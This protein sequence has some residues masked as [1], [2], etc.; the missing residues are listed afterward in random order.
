MPC[1]NCSNRLARPMVRPHANDRRYGLGLVIC[2]ELKRADGR[3][4]RVESKPEKSTVFTVQLPCKK[5]WPCTREALQD[6]DLRGK[7]VL[8][9]GNNPTNAKTLSSHLLSFGHEL[10]HCQKRCARLLKFSDQTARLG[11]SYDIALVVWKHWA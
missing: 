8:G 11:Q 7:R 9:R 1:R 4:I 3:T 6:T 10:S 2:K 5:H